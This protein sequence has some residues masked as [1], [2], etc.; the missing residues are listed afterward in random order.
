M[1]FDVNAWLAKRLQAAGIT[2]PAC[3]EPLSP[4]EVKRQQAQS[5]V[6]ITWRQLGIE[7]RY[8][9]G[10]LYA[11]C[12]TMEMSIWIPRAGTKEQTAAWRQLRHA[13]MFAFDVQCDLEEHVTGITHAQAQEGVCVDTVKRR[14]YTQS[15]SVIWHT[16]G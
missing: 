12:Y 15:I 4:D 6:Y 13:L 1:T 11:V 16:G 2:C 7:P 10:E 9:S 5:T 8:A 14:V 3:E